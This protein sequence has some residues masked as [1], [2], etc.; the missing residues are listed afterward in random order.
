MEHVVCT[1]DFS[2]KELRE[3]IEIV[4]EQRSIWI[5][6]QR[7]RSLVAQDRFGWVSAPKWRMHRLAYRADRTGD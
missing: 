3:A 7:G 6:A 4:I 1:V 5:G 2:F